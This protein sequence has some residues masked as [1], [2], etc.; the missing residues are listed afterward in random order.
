MGLYKIL[1]IVAAVLGLIGVVFLIMILTDN[2]G[3]ISSYLSVAYITL[4]VAILFTLL[5][6]VTQLFKNPQALKK[7]L[8]SLG[9]FLAIVLVSFFISTG[10]AVEKA[11]IEVIS[12]Y[13]SKWV[14]AGLYTFYILALVAIGLMI[15]SGVKKLINN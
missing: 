6:S 2:T 5:F 12:E 3:I 11:G 10:E 14:G 7:T 9:L 4:G 15:Y 1:R 13:G 8:I